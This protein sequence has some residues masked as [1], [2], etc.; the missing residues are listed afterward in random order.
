LPAISAIAVAAVSALLS[1]CEPANSQPRGGMPPPEVAVV[2]VQ[3]NRCPATFEYVGQNGRLARGR[4]ARA[5]DR[6][7]PENATIAKARRLR[8]GS[9]MFTIDPAPFEVAACASRSRAHERRGEA[10]AG[11]AHSAR[12]KPL[13]EIKAASQKDYDDAGFGGAGGRGG[14]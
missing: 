9:R 2:T 11:E 7:G 5:R 4:G 13:F 6:I 12:L 1:G 14:G 3:L 8:R 10:R